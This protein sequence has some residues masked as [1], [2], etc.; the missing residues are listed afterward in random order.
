MRCLIIF[1]VFYNCACAWAQP[2]YVTCDPDKY[3]CA[4]Q[5]G[6]PDNPHITVPVECCTADW[7]ARHQPPGLPASDPETCE[8]TFCDKCSTTTPQSSY[9]CLMSPYGKVSFCGCPYEAPSLSY[10]PPPTPPITPVPLF[11]YGQTWFSYNFNVYGN[12]TVLTK[13]ALVNATFVDQILNV[14]SYAFNS[15]LSNIPENLVWTNG[16]ALLILPIVNSHTILQAEI[17]VQRPTKDYVRV[18]KTRSSLACTTCDCLTKNV[19]WKNDNN[20]WDQD[21]NESDDFYVTNPNCSP[22]TVFGAD[23]A[24]ATNTTSPFNTDDLARTYGVA[25]GIPLGSAF[26][27]GFGY[28][29]MSSRL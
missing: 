19:L 6:D 16:Q 13:D 22:P 26:V 28:T 9:Q 18:L 5:R 27:L 20:T 24:G 14:A 8:L 3:S 4:G 1:F 10:T 25:F 23:A 21:S 2:F 7:Q 15:D 11:P 12:E 17:W 29:F